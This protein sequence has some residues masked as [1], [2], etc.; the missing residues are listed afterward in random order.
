MKREISRINR[1]LPTL[2]TEGIQTDGIQQ[3]I[4][5]VLRRMEHFKAEHYTCV[6]EAMTLLE[7]AVWKAVIDE[8]EGEDDSQRAKAKK[9]KMDMKAVRRERRVTSGADI[10]VKNVLPF[11][12]LE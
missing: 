5:S 12:K 10:V 8:N 7:L 2:N 4:E 3:W 11:L 6:R 1:A 9:V